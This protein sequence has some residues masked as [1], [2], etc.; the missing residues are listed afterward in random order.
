MAAVLAFDVLTQNRRRCLRDKASELIQRN[1]N[2]P[3]VPAFAPVG[4]AK[5]IVTLGLD[6]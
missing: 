3:L 6:R 5:A 2:L 4:D 1:Q